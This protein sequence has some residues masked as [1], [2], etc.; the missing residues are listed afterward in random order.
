M[1]PRELLG[2]ATPPPTPP[3]PTPPPPRRRPAEPAHDAPPPQLSGYVS[4][5]AKLAGEVDQL[6]EKLLDTAQSWNI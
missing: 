2:D 3:P 6:R 5:T 4:I 1:H